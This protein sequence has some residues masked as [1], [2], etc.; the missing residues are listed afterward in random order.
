MKRT[1][2]VGK[3]PGHPPHL[4]WNP[5]LQERINRLLGEGSYTHWTSYCR[6]VAGAPNSSGFA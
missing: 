3:P 6:G 1:T 5:T 4:P 2:K